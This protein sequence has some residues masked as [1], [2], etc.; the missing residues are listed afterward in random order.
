MTLP[1]RSAL[2]QLTSANLGISHPLYRTRSHC[3]VYLV[4][5]ALDR[6]VYHGRYSRPHHNPQLIFN[7]QTHLKSFRLQSHP[8]HSLYSQDR[9]LQNFHL[10]FAFRF[11]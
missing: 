4:F 9:H 1:K 10:E 2:T 3:T 7:P 6:V 11:V 5:S 8:S